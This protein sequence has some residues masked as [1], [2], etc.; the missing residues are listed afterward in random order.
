[1]SSAS[2]ADR[3]RHVKVFKALPDA[4]REAMPTLSHVNGS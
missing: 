2:E 1:M 3:A 4:R